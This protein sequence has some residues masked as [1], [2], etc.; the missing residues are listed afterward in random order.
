MEQ[1]Y[2]KRNYKILEDK[3]IE[4]MNSA[5]EYGKKLINTELDAGLFTFIIKPVVRTF[6]D[7]WCTNDAREGTL[8]QIKVTLD[9]ALILL[10]NGDS[11]EL[12]NKVIEE[13]FPVYLNGDQTYRQCKKSH[14]NYEKLE[15]IT[16]EAFISQVR[17]S[18]L[19]LRIRENVDN[20]DDLVKVAFKDKQ[21]AYESLMRQLNYNEAG[22]AIVEKDPSILKIPT[23]KSTILKALRKGF[24]KTKTDLIE[25]LDEIFD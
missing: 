3:M 7:Y 16:K 13:H 19:F 4:Q 6:Y 2:I 25:S 23:G 5:L 20:Y 22:I 10:S 15:E 11:E 14:K 12:F 9:S 18:L 1:E 17:E 24:E 21:K 8:Q